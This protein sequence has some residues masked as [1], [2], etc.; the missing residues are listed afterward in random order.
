MTNKFE[1]SLLRFEV[2]DSD[3]IIMRTGGDLFPKLFENEQR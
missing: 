1:R 2:P 3:C